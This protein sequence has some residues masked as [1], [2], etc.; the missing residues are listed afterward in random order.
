[1]TKAVSVFFALALAVGVTACARNDGGSP[2]ASPDS[3][4]RSTTSDRPAGTTGSPTTGTS[5]SSTTGSSNS[6]SGSTTGGTTR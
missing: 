5:G 6:N 2:S 1:M 4:R 3:S